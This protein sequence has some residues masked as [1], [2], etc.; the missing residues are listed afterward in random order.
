MADPIDE[1][2]AVLMT[3]GITNQNICTNIIEREGFTELADLATLVTDRD[4]DEMAKRMAARTQ[5]E[6]RVFLGTVTVQRMKTLV[7]W[8]NDQLKR[9]IDLQA[10]NFTPEVM[11]RSAQEKIVRA[12]LADTEPTI[13]D[14][15]KFDPDDFD[16]YE[17]AFLNLL[18]QTFGVLKEPLRYVVRPTLVPE[19]F[20]NNQEERMY[21][22]PLEGDAFD[23][24]N[25][26]VYRK[27][28]AFLIN[29]PGW[30]W[31]E[32]HDTAE[33]GRAAFKAWTDHYNGEGELSK[34]TAIAKTKLDQVHYRNERSLPFEKCIEIMTKCFNTLHKDP[35]ERY[36]DRRKVEKLLKMI[37]C[38]DTELLAAKSLIDE[39]FSRDYIGACSFFSKQVARV[40]GPAQLEYKQSRGKKRGVY[41]VDSRSQRGGRGRG[42]QAN[43]GRGRG[44][45]GRGGRGNTGTTII[46][47]ID[48]S[49]PNRS[50]TPQEWNTLG[51]GR[52]LVLQMRENR[53]G[54]GSG[55]GRDQAGRG[56]GN[57]N[58]RNV[59]AVDSN[60]TPNQD[61]STTTPTSTTDRGGRNGRGFGR[62]AYSNNRT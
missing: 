47:G 18:G 32:P 58:E 61:E 27:L 33:D 3:I 52:S 45:G 42:R 55:R 9:G 57:D 44:R 13:T 1:L 6:G 14:L 46:N 30:A 39:R 56:R 23:A 2:N 62:G 37:K 35:D 17:D 25:H 40:H 41:A 26:S 48:V 8:V 20:A 34:R 38:Q 11:K 5:N 24:D 29:S 15:G 31:I 10:V 54:R 43:R 7:W 12:E 60:D 50:F 53:Q 59:S 36:S 21:Q 16:T 49:D 22:L 51:S 4:V 19:E 28:K